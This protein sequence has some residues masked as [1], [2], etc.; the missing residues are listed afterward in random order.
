MLAETVA[1]FKTVGLDVGMEKTHWTCRPSE[2]GIAIGI[3]GVGVV[4]EPYLTFVGG[5]LDFNGNSGNAIEHR[6]AQAEKTYHKW[7]PLLTS[8]WVSQKR[9]AELAVRAVISSLLWLSETWA[10]TKAQTRRLDSF[11]GRADG[12][13]GRGSAITDG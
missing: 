4:W 6:I 13:R 2:E 5:V 3:D 12:A 9:R 1:A 8:R 11:W 10:P 7:K